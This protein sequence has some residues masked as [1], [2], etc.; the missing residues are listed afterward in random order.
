MADAVRDAPALLESVERVLGE[1]VAATERAMGPDL[2]AVVLYGSA[3]EG[4]LRA[5]SDVNLLVVLGAWHPDRVDELRDPLRRAH[6]A[7]RLQPMFLLESEIAGAVEAFSVKFSDILRRRRVLSGADPFAGV[8]VSREAEIARLR[9]VLLNLVMRLR[10][11]YVM[12]SL[13]E[14]QAALVLAETTAPLRACAT[15]LL[16]IE[17]KSAVSPKAALAQ[18]AAALPGE[19]WQPLLDQLS[20]AREGQVLAPGVAPAALLRLID[21]AEAMRGLLP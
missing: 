14:E 15:A 11:R 10:E 19:T 17:G 1:V 3:A 13:R 9:Q 20:Q 6:A 8:S 18:V 12:R 5:T 4:R 2:R 16:E 7:I 21:L